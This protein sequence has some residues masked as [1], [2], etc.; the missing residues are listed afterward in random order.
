[1]LA[2]GLSVSD[3]IHDEDQSVELY[4]TS[5]YSVCPLRS[6]IVPKHFRL[7]TVTLINLCFTEEQGNSKEYT[8]KGNLVKRQDEICFFPRPKNN[9]STSRSTLML[10]LSTTKLRQMALAVVSC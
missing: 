6:S 2:T 7:D 3:A 4:G 8:T 9:A 10:L 1:M 5:V